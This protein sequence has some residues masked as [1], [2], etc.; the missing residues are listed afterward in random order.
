MSELVSA[1]RSGAFCALGAAYQAKYHRLAALVLLGGAGI[2][3]CITFVWL[4]APDLAITQLVV[5][6]VTTVLLLLGLRWLPKRS[7][8]VDNAVSLA[9]RSRRFRD[10]LLALA[11]LI[12]YVLYAYMWII[13]I[14]ALLSWVN[15]DPWNP[16]VR[17]LYQVTE[18]VLRPIRQR[19]PATGIDFSPLVVILGIYFLQWFLVP[20][21]VKTAYRI[22]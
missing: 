7:E 5:E 20:V 6:V 11:K 22:G 14:R 12:D 16:I 2:T 18:P 3:T 19:L 1:P 4:S 15:P 13:V 21:L 17:F 9:A 10:F 8:K